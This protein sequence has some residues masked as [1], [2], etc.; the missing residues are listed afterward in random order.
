MLRDSSVFTVDDPRFSTARVVG[1]SMLSLDG[2]EHKRHRDPFADAFRRAEAQARLEEFVVAEAGRLVA[3][4]AAAGRAELRRSLAGP[5]AV[6]A[7]AEVLG[8]GQADPGVILS[9]YDEIVAA[10]AALAGETG[11]RPLAGCARPGRPRPGARL[12]GVRA[13][14]AEPADGDRPPGRRLAARGGGPGAT[15][16]A[17]ARSCRTRRC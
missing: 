8:L 13:A 12:G 9:W 5:L 17:T 1:P 15:G 10:V 3:S 11:R 4:F 16:C 14:R 7:V 2:A 6:A